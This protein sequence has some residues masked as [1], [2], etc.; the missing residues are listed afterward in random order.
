M[1]FGGMS[2]VTVRAAGT[3]EALRGQ[4]WRQQTLPHLFE[5]LT[6]ELSLPAAVPGGQASGG[7][8]WCFCT[9]PSVCAAAFVSDWH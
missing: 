2:K 4:L 3:E 5:A 8:W 6:A 9:P 1:A 7:G